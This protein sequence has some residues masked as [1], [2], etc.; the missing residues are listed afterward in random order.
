MKTYQE[1]ES[2]VKKLQSALDDLKKADVKLESARY[3]LASQDRLRP[4]LVR[5]VLECAEQSDLFS[6]ELQRMWEEQRE[7][8]R[9]PLSPSNVL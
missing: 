2:D 6:E 7:P 5:A 3:Q 4:L 1:I 9:I 8:T